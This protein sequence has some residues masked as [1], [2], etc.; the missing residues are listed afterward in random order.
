MT[1]FGSKV[2]KIKCLQNSEYSRGLGIADNTT[3]FCQQQREEGEREKLSGFYTM[4]YIFLE[5]KAF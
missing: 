5:L 4:T 1:E 2:G 3:M